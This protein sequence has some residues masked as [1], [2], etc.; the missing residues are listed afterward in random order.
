MPNPKIVILILFTLTACRVLAQ[1]TLVFEKKFPLLVTVVEESESRIIYKKYP[2]EPGDLPHV[3]KKRFVTEVRYENKEEGKLK[4]K[5]DSLGLERKLDIWV[6][7]MARPGMVSGFLLSRNDSALVVRKKAAGF[8]KKTR[9]S[10]EVVHIFPYQKI[11]YI[12]VR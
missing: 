5:S 12:T 4:F 8:G 9:N 2:P 7:P 1:D 11:N 3:M 6:S 10:P